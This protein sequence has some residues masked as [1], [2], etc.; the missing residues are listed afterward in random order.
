MMTFLIVNRYGEVVKKLLRCRD[1]KHA[2]SKAI[3]HGFLG[4]RFYV[5]SNEEYRQQ[6]FASPLPEK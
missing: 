3:K 5:L 4:D 6:K 2:C 1:K